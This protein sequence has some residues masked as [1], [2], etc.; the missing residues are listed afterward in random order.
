ML[1][2]PLFPTGHFM[3]GEAV[4]VFYMTRTA[5]CMIDELERWED[6]FFDPIRED[7]VPDTFMHCVTACE[8]QKLCGHRIGAKLM[9]DQAN[10]IREDFYGWW[11]NDQDGSARDEQAN[12]DGWQCGECGGDCVDCCESTGY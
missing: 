5:R 4:S 8:I 1:H 11:N 6:F 10:G 9:F 2:V 12:S 7:D 3:I